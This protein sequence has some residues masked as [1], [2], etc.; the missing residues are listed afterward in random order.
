MSFGDIP[1]PTLHKNSVLIAPSFVGLNFADIYRRQGHYI[2]QGEAAWIGGYEGVGRIVAV[3]ADVLD[4][5]IG[6]RVGFA[7]VPRAH[8]SL[9]VALPD[10]LVTLPDDVEDENVAALLLQGLTAQYLLENSGALR[11]GDQILIQAAAGGVG[12]LLTQMA[13]A[14][15]AQVYALASTPGKRAQA[16]ENGAIATYG[17]E[18]DWVT[19]IQQDT[20]KGV[21]IAYDSVGTTL[22][23]SMAV[24]RPGGRAVIFGKAGGQP[25]LINPLD[26]M[27]GS[28]AIIGGDLWTYLDS[29]KSRQDRVNRLFASL[30]AGD[31]TLPR[32]QSFPL[33]AG[34][35]AHRLLEDRNFA[36][37]IVLSTSQLR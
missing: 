32:I 9:V 21:D 30:A 33:S 16:R 35:D 20:G 14:R 10:Q 11:A 27:E 12:R 5:K 1:S 26:L 6:Q 28:K 36:G 15:G 22:M 2:L 18:Q 13:T 3:G 19:L 7:D 24:L 29:R 25:P 23:K 8:S 17:Y 34:Q 37:K 4:W 31:I